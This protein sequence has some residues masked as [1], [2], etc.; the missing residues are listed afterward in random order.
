MKIRNPAIIKWI[1]FL[2]AIIIRAWIGTLSFRYRSL[3]EN[4]YP[5]RGVKER[6]LY[7]FWHEYLLLPAVRFAFT[8]A[9]ILIGQHAD[10][11]LITENLYRYEPFKMFSADTEIK[12]TELTDMPPAAPPTDSIR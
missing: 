12:F 4:V 7:A 8:D 6:Y 5:D 11:Q 1:G 10:G 9:T 3:G 2:G